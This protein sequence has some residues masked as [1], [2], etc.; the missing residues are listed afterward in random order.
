MNEALTSHLLA[1]AALSA[2]VGSRVY[3]VRRPQGDPLP[4]VVI[5]T[6]D[7]LPDYTSQG[8]SGLLSSRIQFDCWGKTY[9][10]AKSVARAVAQRLSGFKGTV[11]GVVFQGGFLEGERDSYEEGTGKSDLFRV[12]LDFIIWTG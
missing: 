1:F 5:H 9:A 12:S 4:A 7:G 6:I 11:S 8:P 3:P 2:L 10:S